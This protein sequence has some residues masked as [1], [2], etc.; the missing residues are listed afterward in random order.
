MTISTTLAEIAVKK[1]RDQS[2]MRMRDVAEKILDTST[3]VKK[4]DSRR[5]FNDRKF[6]EEAKLQRKKRELE[7]SST[8]KNFFK[9]V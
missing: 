6:V 8:Y 1:L 7:Q 2:H 4:D 5:D 9:Y 3:E